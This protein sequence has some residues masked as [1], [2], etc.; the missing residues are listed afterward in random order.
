MSRYTRQEVIDGRKCGLKYFDEAV[1]KVGIQAILEQTVAT[2]KHY[3]YVGIGWGNLYWAFG[4]TWTKIA[5]Y[6]GNA[7]ENLD[8][9]LTQEQIRWLAE[10]LGLVVEDYEP[11]WKRREPVKIPSRRRSRSSEKLSS[12]K[13]KDLLIR[14]TEANPTT[15]VPY[16]WTNA[17]V[18][19]RKVTLSD[20]SR[21][22]KRKLSGQDRCQSRTF[23][24]KC[25]V[26][27]DESP[28]HFEVISDPDDEQ[29]VLVTTGKVTNDRYEPSAVL[30][31]A[32]TG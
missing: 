11:Q 15:F 1:A 23:E 5:G 24:I 16:K 6:S 18:A 17:T 22:S 28:T 30:F 20:I 14:L 19:D 25:L 27:T 10:Q 9:V 29:I 13:I 7:T 21:V 31:S 4:T 8:E 26:F 3:D 12:G 2:A 32:T